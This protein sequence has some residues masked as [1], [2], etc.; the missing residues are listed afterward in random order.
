MLIDFRELAEHKIQ[1]MNNGTGE[2]SAKM[3]M[4][5]Q[6]KLFRVLFTQAVLSVCISIIPVMILTM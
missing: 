6:E 4:D 1:G 2:M 3:Y 5:E